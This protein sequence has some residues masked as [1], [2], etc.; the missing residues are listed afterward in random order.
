M[1]TIVNAE[2]VSVG[3]ELLLGQI[4]D[5]NAAFIGRM[6]AE[7]G[8]GSLQRQTVGDNLDRVTK[9]IS[10][11][12]ARADLVITIGGLGP[13]EDDLTRD[14]VAAAL[15][16]ELTLDPELEVQLRQLFAKRNLPWLDTQ[17][18]QA[19]RPQS[20]RPLPNPNGTA[21]GLICEKEGKIV[22]CLPGPPS[23]LGPMVEDFVRPFL[24]E[25]SGGGIILSR[26]VRIIGVGESM[27]E[28][29]VKD[30]ITSDNPTVAPLAHTGE[31][32]LRITARAANRTQAAELIRPVEDAIR[33]RL[34]KAIYGC[35]ADTLEGSCL[36]LLR[37]RSATV[38]IAES[39]TGG[40]LG[41]RLTSIAGSSDV[42]VGG[43]IT[44]ANSMKVK[45]LGVTEETLVQHGAVSAECAKE[46]AVGV[47][48]LCSADYTLAVTGIAGPG[49]GSIEKPVGLVYIGVVAPGSI[50]AYEYNFA[51]SRD[52]IRQRSVQ[53]ALFRLREALLA[54]L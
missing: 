12:M 2:V 4:V 53:A 46:M 17:L 38:A 43:A 34:G 48:E 22:I 8:I 21:P 40:M 49:G 39:C 25:R 1:L 15:G 3:T 5:T 14:A 19:M 16:E 11:A 47:K 29:K 44:Y 54:D 30:L 51:G 26:V 45:L 20:S 41:A 42:V 7:V 9:A 10:A 24:A 18:R 13:T 52:M 36:E 35:D 32:H 37:E 27:V 6:L 31:V 23:E 28:A 33:S 50:E